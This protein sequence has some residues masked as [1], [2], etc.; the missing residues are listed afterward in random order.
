MRPLLLLVVLA[1]VGCKDASPCRATCLRVA[2]CREQARQGEKMLGEKAP[3]PDPRC[4]KRCEEE[5]E[6][7]A[8]CEEKMKS[9]SELQ[10]CYGPLR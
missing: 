5:P 8:S 3:P 7:W 1:L 2:A 9:C 10:S 4:M 6:V